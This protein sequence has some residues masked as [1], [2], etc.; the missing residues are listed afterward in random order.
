MACSGAGLPSS[1]VAGAAAGIASDTSALLAARSV[2][3]V[4]GVV[5]ELA[6]DTSGMPVCGLVEAGVRTWDSE[7]GLKCARVEA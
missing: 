1:L 6:V 4:P 3:A 2:V 5:A 7:G